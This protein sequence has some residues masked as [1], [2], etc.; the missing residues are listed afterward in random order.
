MCI[1]YNLLVYILQNSFKCYVMWSQ[2]EYDMSFYRY[3]WYLKTA[4]ILGP[5]EVLEKSLNFVL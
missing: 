3:F 4:I 1:T 5:W 2:L